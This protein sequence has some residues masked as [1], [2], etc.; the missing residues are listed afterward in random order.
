MTILLIILIDNSLNSRIILTLF[1]VVVFIFFAIKIFYFATKCLELVANLRLNFFFSFKPFQFIIINTQNNSHS[2]LSRPEGKS[3]R[4]SNS[5]SIW[6]P[7]TTSLR[8]TKVESQNARKMH[9]RH[10]KTS[11]GP[12]GRNEK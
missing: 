4:S 5:H 9:K 11:S 7:K 8:A 12:L 2:S 6:I 1:Q 10:F 3:H